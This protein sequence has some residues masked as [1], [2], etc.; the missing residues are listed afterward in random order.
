[1]ITNNLGIWCDKDVLKQLHLSNLP[2]FYSITLLTEVMSQKAHYSFYSA[3]L[4]T[5]ER[6]PKLVHYIGKRL[7]FEMLPISAFGR[8]CSI[9]VFPKLNPSVITK[10]YSELCSQ[11]TCGY[12]IAFMSSEWTVSQMVPYSLCSALLLIWAFWTQ[13]STI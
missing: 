4:L 3:L 6:W 5:I 13:Y 12:R 8:T 10:L 2:Q 7:S 1:M 11:R 9:V